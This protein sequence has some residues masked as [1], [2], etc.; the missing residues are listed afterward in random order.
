MKLDVVI[1]PADE[2]CYWPE[3]LS[4]PGYATQRADIEGLLKNSRDAVEGCLSANVGHVT[5]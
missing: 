4:M 2:G 3:V 5:I 1:H